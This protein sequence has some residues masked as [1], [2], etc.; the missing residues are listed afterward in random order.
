MRAGKMW[1]GQ[2]VRRFSVIAGLSAI[3][4]LPLM[5]LVSF[6]G[7]FDAKSSVAHA[8]SSTFTASADTF[9]SS[10]APN[11]TYGSDTKMTACGNGAPACSVDTSDEKR[12]LV[13]FT[14]NGL[15][16]QT[17]TSVK[18][19]Y[20]VTTAPAPVLTVKK[21]TDNTWTEAAANWTN[22]NGL[23]TDAVS[24]TSNS[25]TAAGWY[26]ANITGAVTGDGT[27]SFFLLSSDTASTRIA[28][29]ETA[30]PVAPAQLMVDSFTPTVSTFNVAE[31]T[32]LTTAGPNTTYGTDTKLVTCGNGANLCNVD[33]SDE[34]RGLLK[35][36]VSGITGSVSNVRLR[37]RVNTTNLPAFTIKKV[38]TNTWTEAAATWNNSNGLPTDP[39]TYTSPTG[40]AA[41]W[42]EAD[43]TGSVNSDGTYS[44]ELFNTD[45]NPTRIASKE[46]TNPA[47]AGAQ[48]I[49]TTGVPDP[50]IDAAGDISTIT[51]TGGNKMTS[52]LILALSPDKVVTLG[53]NQYDHGD[54]A[55]FNT[56]FDP[57]WG[58]F[59]S[60][61]YPTPGHHEYNFDSTA[62]GYYTYF[63]AAATPRNTSCASACEGYYSW[64]VGNWH[65]VALNTNHNDCA[66]VACDATSAQVS[67]LTADLAA[68]T[69]PCVAAYFADPRWSSG[70]EHGSNPAMGPIWNA[71]YAAK[72]DVVLNGH[73]H[74]YER[75][76][77]QDPSGSAV[78]D[79]IRQFIVGTGGNAPLYPFGTAITNSEVRDNSTRGVLQLKLHTNSYEW[80]FK[81]VT[82]GTFTDSGSSAC[83]S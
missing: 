18:L 54:L 79:G 72:V 49:V 68:T 21:V 55:D 34:K 24:Y 5:S 59:K 73:E 14:V 43:V 33:N 44:F 38:T 2:L 23:P 13:K 39:A 50:V 1:P 63:G 57:T 37:Y 22:S 78:S 81:P 28:T 17:V 64:D 70:T 75:F 66:Y 60:K 7:G 4:A 47:N 27:Y 58:R 3:V 51:T 42:Y 74:F 76:A 48:L 83:N 35:F 16:G 41:G 46:S 30:S 32:T 10:V 69:K 40:T 53:D 19:R 31:D 67:W 77:K 25:G 56:Y 6:P 65:M 80:E 52:D 82:G 62:A 9:L 20:Y 12:P 15:T 11:T 26:E 8:A 29:K 36:N 61:I 45:A 71:L